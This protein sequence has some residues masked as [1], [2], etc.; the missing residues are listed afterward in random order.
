MESFFLF[1]KILFVK[2][3]FKI[4][5]ENQHF[6]I[7][8]QSCKSFKIIFFL[9][10]NSSQPISKVSA[11]WFTICKSNFLNAGHIC[12]IHL[13]YWTTF[14]LR[15]KIFYCLRSFINSLSNLFSWVAF[16]AIKVRSASKP[17][18]IRVVVFPPKVTQ[19]LIKHQI[20]NGIPKW[21]Y[22]GIFKIT[23][24]KRNWIRKVPL[25]FMKIFQ[26]LLDIFPSFLYKGLNLN[27]Y[28]KILLKL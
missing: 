18:Y 22:Y 1:F 5:I 20:R 8:W 2:T 12:L 21:F 11:T 13:N 26:T 14:F 17:W 15:F 6:A 4:Q 19:N 28:C 25:H 10:F 7:F 27:F 23:F 16:W 9:T 24:L 3:Y